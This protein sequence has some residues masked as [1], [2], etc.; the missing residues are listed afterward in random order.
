MTSMVVFFKSKAFNKLISRAKEQN[1]LTPEEINEALP[2]N[3]VSPDKIDEILFKIKELNIDIETAP[4]V[5]EKGGR[6]QVGWNG[7]YRRGLVK[8]RA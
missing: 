7:D 2:A 4:A 8:R 5:E 1:H 6:N 3:I